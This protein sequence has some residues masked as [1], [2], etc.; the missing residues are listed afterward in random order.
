MS[1]SFLMLLIFLHAN[2][3]IMLARFVAWYARC[4]L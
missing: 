2:N 4:C 3:L 1:H